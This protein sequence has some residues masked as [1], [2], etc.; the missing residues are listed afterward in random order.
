MFEKLIEYKEMREAIQK[1]RSLHSPANSG[2]CSDPECCSPYESEEFCSEC[3]NYE[4]PCKTIKI[5]D[6]DK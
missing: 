2:G 4:Y 3:Q 1:I 5:L 6:G